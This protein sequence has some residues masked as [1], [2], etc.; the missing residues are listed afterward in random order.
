MEGNHSN[1]W[2]VVGPWNI[3]PYYVSEDFS[4]PVLNSNDY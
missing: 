1:D 3:S 2:P 4:Y